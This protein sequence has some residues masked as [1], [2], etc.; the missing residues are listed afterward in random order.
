[1]SVAVPTHEMKNGV[2]FLTRLLDSLWDQSFQD[3]EIVVTDNSDGNELKD[4]C[5]Y[6]GSTIRYFKNPEKG[7]AV[8]TNYAME[9]SMGEVIKMIYMDDFLAHEDSLQNIKTHFKGQWLVT[10]CTHVYGFDSDYEQ[11]FNTHIPTFHSIDDMIEGRNTIGSP[12]VLTVRNR[13]H[14]NFDGGLIVTGKP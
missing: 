11:R 2:K 13:E 3:F 5:E 12:S 10:A 9:K 1:M 8:N 14:L 6:Y 7:M 4:L